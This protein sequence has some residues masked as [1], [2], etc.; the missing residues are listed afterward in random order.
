MGLALGLML[1]ASGPLYELFAGGAYFAM[2]A[3][4]ALGTALA[5]VLARRN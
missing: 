1:L 5:V 2:A 4:A 3:S